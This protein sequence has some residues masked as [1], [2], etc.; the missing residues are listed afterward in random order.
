MN[1]FF[2]VAGYVLAASLVSIFFYILL[3]FDFE[4]QG[5][6]GIWLFILVGLLWPIALL[7]LLI[8]WLAAPFE[9][10][11][12][13]YAVIKRRVKT[14]KMEAFVDSLKAELSLEERHALVEH[15]GHLAQS[16]EVQAAF[17]NQLERLS[18]ESV[19]RTIEADWAYVDQPIEVD[20]AYDGQ[21]HEDPD[22]RPSVW[23]RKAEPEAGPD[24]WGVHMTSDFRK[25][26]RHLDKTMRVRVLNA[27]SEISQRPL[28]VKGDTVKPLAGV[29]S[30][31]WR[32]RMGD[33]RLIYQPHK[34]VRR[35]DM[36]SICPRGDAYLH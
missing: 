20:W 8:G 24:E 26:V 36:I 30:G 29:L 15:L 35:I 7:L 6:K 22:A 18:E 21:P 10:I 19:K 23:R 3:K 9:E 5:F 28:D 27:I 33:Y 11:Q 16:S 14:K 4:Q 25:A 12:T 31:Y 34:D 2:L 1:I 13:R 32:Y 17:V